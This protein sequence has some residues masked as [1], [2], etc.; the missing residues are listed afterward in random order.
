MRRFAGAATERRAT[1]EASASPRGSFPEAG[2]LRSPVHFRL[3]LKRFGETIRS[4]SPNGR[5]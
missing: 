3:L 4:L 1:H 5:R 2:I